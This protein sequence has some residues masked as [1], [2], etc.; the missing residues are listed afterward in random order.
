[1]T[2]MITNR[3]LKKILLNTT[4]SILLLGPRQVGKSTLLR[5]LSPDL[6]I[7]LSLESEFFKFTSNPNYFDSLLENFKSGTVLI[8]EVQRLPSLLNSVQ[9][10]IDEAKRNKKNLRFLLSGSSARKLKRGNANLLPGRIFTF[11]LSGLTAAE[12]DYNLDLKK[13]V[14]IGFLPEPYLESNK[15]L[16]QKILSQ[17]SASYLK[18]E[19]QAEALT[20]DITG[21]SRFL[22]VVAQSSGKIFDF[23][24]SANKAKVSRSKAIQFVEILEDTLIAH[25]LNVFSELKNADTIKH[26]KIYFFDVGVLNGLLE[27]FLASAD[28]IGFLFEHV[29]YSQIRNSL[30]ASDLPIHLFCFRT[31]HGLEVD[32]ILKHKDVTWAIE[33]KTGQ[34]GDDDLVALQEFKKYDLKSKLVVISLNENKARIRNNVLICGLNEF[35]RRLEI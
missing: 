23:S 32:F 17:Y 9:F 22:N 20:R 18:E 15:T 25:R 27:N 28:R 8:D 21:F 16:S 6:I 29:V 5:S 12:V 3:R 35:L 4:K 2:N 31:R 26:P 11:Y 1:M 7:D 19:I 13:S 33:V 34:V 30:I 10:F 24:K 14:Q